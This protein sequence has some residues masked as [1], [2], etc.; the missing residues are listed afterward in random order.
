MMPWLGTHRRIPM[1][2][3]KHVLL[4][5]AIGALFLFAQPQPAAAD[6]ITIGLLLNTDRAF[7]GYTL[8]TP[9]GEGNT[10]LI[11]NDGKV[12]HSWDKGTH[13]NATP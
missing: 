12:V 5:I 1:S 9:V 10:Y 7:E 3:N 6:G 8:F 13:G 2:L 11:D 4:L